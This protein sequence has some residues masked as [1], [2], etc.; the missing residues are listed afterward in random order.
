MKGWIFTYDG[1]CPANQY[2]LTPHSPKPVT[3]IQFVNTPQWGNRT[4]GE[5]INNKYLTKNGKNY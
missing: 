1:T 5:N 3:M 2:D 4:K